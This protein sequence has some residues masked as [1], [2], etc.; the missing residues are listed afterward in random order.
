ML[1]TFLYIALV[2]SC[3]VFTVAVLL[4]DGRGG[5]VSGALGTAGREVMGASNR[6][7]R[8]VALAAAVVFLLTTIGIHLVHQA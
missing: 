2:L 5:G 1:T 3:F 7:M 8:R 6:G 4:Q